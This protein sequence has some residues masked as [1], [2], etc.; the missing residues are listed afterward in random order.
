MFLYGLPPTILKGNNMSEENYLRFPSNNAPNSDYKKDRW[1]YC[2]SG[3]F[4]LPRLIRDDTRLTNL[5]F[6]VLVVLASHIM[7]TDI[8][9]PSLKTLKKYTGISESA[10]SKATKR[11]E[12]KG[13]LKK[14]Q[15]AYNS[16]IYELCLPHDK[17]QEE[18]NAIL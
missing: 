3:Y 18:Q 14:T 15:R 7:M 2:K 1:F 11:L 9:S 6:R 5:E 13:W 16:V 10:I 12:E 8:A 17:T 4:S